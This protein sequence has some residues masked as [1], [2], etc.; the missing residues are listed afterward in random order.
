MKA[1]IY[2][3]L[4]TCTLQAQTWTQLSDLPG[5]ERDDGTAQVINNYCYVGGGLR[6]G[7]TIGNDY[8]RLDLTTNTW[9]TI[10][11]MPSGSERQYASAFSY[12]NNMFVYGGIGYSNAQFN[13]TYKYDVSSNTWTTVASKPGNG[14]WGA[15]SFTL[16]SKAY[17]FC[18]KFSG[19]TISDEVW[20]YDMVANTWTQ[21]NNF[22]FGGRWR[23]SAAVLSNTAYVVFGLDNNGTGSYRKEIY[24]YNQ[25]GDSWTYLASFPQAKGR[26]YS[27]MQPVNGKLVIFGG[28]D[29]LGNVFNDTWYYDETNGFVSGP[30]LPSGGR[31]GGM[32]F[33]SGT[34]FYYTCGVNTTVRLKETWILETFVGI[35]ENIALKGLSFYP[36]PCGNNVFIKNDTPLDFLTLTLSDITGRVLF[37]QE[38]SS[39]TEVIDLSGISSGIYFANMSSNGVVLGT[40]KLIKE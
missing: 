17:V 8:Y 6:S 20:E 11:P 24:K 18:G 5:L 37:S 27:S 12:S 10:A 40:Q 3:F 1:F 16:G 31:K 7:F 39:A 19:G 13:D 32:S 2:L 9:T 14:V 35:K 25:A 15:A 26:V 21:K 36:N 22:P 34:K 33:S 4:L 28:L 30:T 23:A 38:I 29:T